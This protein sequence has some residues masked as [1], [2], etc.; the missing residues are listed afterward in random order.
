MLACATSAADSARVF[1]CDHVTRAAAARSDAQMQAM[2][3]R[4]RGFSE[5]T[6]RVLAECTQALSSSSQHGRSSAGSDASMQQIPSSPP[7][8]QVGPLATVEHQVRFRTCATAREG[9]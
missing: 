2:Q 7:A 9:A 6:Q 3:D 5:A 8:D 1:A 4:C